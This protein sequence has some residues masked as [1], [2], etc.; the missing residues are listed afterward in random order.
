M[1]NDIQPALSGQFLAFFRNERGFVWFEFHSEVE[2]LGVAGQFEVQPGCD[3]FPQ[4]KQVTILNMPTVFTKVCSDAVGSTESRQDG[5]CN[6][7][8]FFGS[9]S[10]PDSRNVIDVNTKTNHVIAL[11]DGD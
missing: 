3:D 1:L 7:V 5:R 6:W 9:T 4:D 8:W 2:D 11:T 10:L